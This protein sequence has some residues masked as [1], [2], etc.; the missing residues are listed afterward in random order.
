MPGEPIGLTPYLVVSDAAA[1]AD[2]YKSAFGATEIA[3]HADPNSK[4]LMHVRLDLFGSLLMFADDFPEMMG[5]KSRTPEALGGTPI[6]LHLQVADADAVW[7][8]AVAAG[9][10]I[11]MPLADQFWGDRYGQLLDPFGHQWSIGQ[12]LH[13]LTNEEVEAAAK[14]TFKPEAK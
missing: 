8:T 6:T 13:Q 14:E 1:A 2:F 11:T 12:S 5:G 7:A 10:K 4:K 3:R 9:A